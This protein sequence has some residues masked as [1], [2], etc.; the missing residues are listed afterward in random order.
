M[1]TVNQLIRRRLLKDVPNRMP[2]LEVL[3]R[4][5]RSREFEEARLNR[6]IFGAMRYGRLGAPG[7]N[8]YDRISDMIRRLLRYD[9]DGNVE[10][11]VDVANLAEC[12]FVEGR[13]Q[14]AAADDGEHTEERA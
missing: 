6:K 14:L 7:K 1:P 10:H 4:T 9:A 13:G 12:E 8:K 11:L 5:E 2:P 3:R